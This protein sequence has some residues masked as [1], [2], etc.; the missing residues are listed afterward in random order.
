MLVNGLSHSISNVE[1]SIFSF[2]IHLFVL[3]FF[4]SKTGSFG[5]YF[6]ASS[7]NFLIWKRNCDKPHNMAKQR[8]DLCFCFFINMGTYF[9]F[10]RS[11]LQI[12]VGN[13]GVKITR[14]RRFIMLNII[15]F[16]STRK[17]I[18]VEIRTRFGTTKVML[19]E[20]QCKWKLQYFRSIRYYLLYFYHYRFLK[21]T[22]PHFTD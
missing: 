4:I 21:C 7:L 22:L 14:L 13:G 6:G 1:S 8:I 3:R 2:I 17:N 5:Q 12:F 20:L 16:L 11:Y 18:A 9:F 15:I 10:T 19:V